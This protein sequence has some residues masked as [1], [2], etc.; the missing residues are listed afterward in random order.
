[1]PSAVSEETEEKLAQ[2]FLQ[3]YH[4]NRFT[5]SR[6]SDDLNQGKSCLRFREYL[7]LF[8]LKYYKKYSKCEKG[9]TASELSELMKVKPPTINP[10]LLNLENKGL[11]S[12]QTDKKDR[13][14]IRIELTQAGLELIEK[15]EASFKKKFHDLACYLG[16]E[17]SRMLAELV[18]EVYA[19]LV[20]RHSNKG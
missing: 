10:M 16:D 3:F 12:R 5:C 18:N 19:F 4:L 2:A 9:M 17:K 11:I 8:Y 15:M 14:Y 20:S 13:R 6:D 7:L 1:M